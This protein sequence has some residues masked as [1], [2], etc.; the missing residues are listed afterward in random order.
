M[1]KD[2]YF[3]HTFTEDKNHKLFKKLEKLG[4]ELDPQMVEHPGK[5][6]CKF[7]RVGEKYLEFVHVR[8][9]GIDMKKPGFS[10]GATQLLRY[11]KKIEKKAFFKL[12]YDHKNYDW[13]ENS[14]DYLPGWNM[15][16]FKNVGNKSI[17]TWFTEYEPDPSRKK[18]KKK[19]FI[20][21]N[22]VSR[23]KGFYIELSPK[24]EKLY[25]TLLGQKLKEE[26]TLPDG[27][28]FYF[29]FS[30]RRTRYHAVILESQNLKKTKSFIPKEKVI[31]FNGQEAI[32]IENPH[33][34]ANMWDIY[35]VNK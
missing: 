10:F 11:K 25:E 21:K 22:A 20:H 14:T 32:K 33:P 34:R 8:P 15:L 18:K 35:I 6:M 7:I 1:Y 28:I 27:T 16:T 30:K 31:D 26:M 24:G 4:F 19:N 9:G 13:K 2:I 23:I 3:D 17:Y 12:N 5:A 29:K